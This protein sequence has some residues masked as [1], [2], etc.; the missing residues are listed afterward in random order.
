VHHMHASIQK[1]L[2]R[3]SAPLEL[4]LQKVVSLD[5]GARKQEP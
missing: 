4:K 3:V 5:M 2:K 1:G